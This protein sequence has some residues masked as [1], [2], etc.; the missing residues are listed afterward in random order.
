MMRAMYIKLNIRNIHC[1]SNY[2][3]RKKNPVLFP[4]GLDSASTDFKG[5]NERG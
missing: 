3:E 2:P 4:H 1:V 5:A